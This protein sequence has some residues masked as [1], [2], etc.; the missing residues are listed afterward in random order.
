MARSLRVG[1]AILDDE[2]VIRMCA[3][4]EVHFLKFIRVDDR[5][6]HPTSQE[7][8]MNRTSLIAA[9][10]TFIALSGAGSAFAVEG[11]QDFS[12]TSSLSSQSREAVRSELAAAARVGA[13]VRG[14]AS[15]APVPA[16][17]QS[18]AVIVAET[19]EALRL[20]V[21]G[22]DEAE[23]RIA[24]PSQQEAIRLAGLRASEGTNV[25]Q[26]R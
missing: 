22:S 10:T 1:N 8:L 3:K 14:E 13:L 23:I 6:L 19:R 25:A 11:T 9:V 7:H 20:G 4:R 5:H 16:S 24:T 17:T 26:S 18:R 2:F 21:A 15:A 12:N